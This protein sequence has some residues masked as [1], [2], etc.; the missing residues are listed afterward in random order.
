MNIDDHNKHVNSIKSEIT[1]RRKID[2]G[3]ITICINSGE[4][5]VGKINSFEKIY[6]N[7]SYLDFELD[8]ILPGPY[9]R[10]FSVIDIKEVLSASKIDIDQ[11]NSSV[12]EN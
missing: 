1:F 8:L 5:I 9:L 3:V 6:S 2:K 11:L 7:T 10:K 12:F 4:I